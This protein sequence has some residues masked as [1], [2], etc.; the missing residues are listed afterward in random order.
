MRKRGKA[1]ELATEY[2]YDLVLMDHMMPGLDEVE[3]TA[4]IRGTEKGRDVPIVA[5]TANAASGMR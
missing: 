2:E 5:L 4:V 3:A 1:I